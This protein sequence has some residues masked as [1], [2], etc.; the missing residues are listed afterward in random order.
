MTEEA[1]LRQEAEAR[2]ITV[3]DAELDEEIGS[4]FNYFDGELPTP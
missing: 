4:F 3:T 1:L 2:G